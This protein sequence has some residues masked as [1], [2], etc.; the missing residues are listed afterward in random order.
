[1][2]RYCLEFGIPTIGV[3]G[4]GLDRIYPSKNNNLARKMVDSGGLL[5]EFI[6][7]T[8]P[9]RENFPKRN[10]IVAGLCDATIIIESKLKGG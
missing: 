7:G 10:R 8:N 9:A 4:H 5:T 6:H 2:H 3:L 1:V